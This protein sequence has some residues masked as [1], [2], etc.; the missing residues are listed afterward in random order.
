MTLALGLF[1]AAVVVLFFATGSGPCPAAHARAAANV[2]FAP[3]IPST[4]GK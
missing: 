1:I 4:E 2:R 3:S